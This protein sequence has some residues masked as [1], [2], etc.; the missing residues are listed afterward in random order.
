MEQDF[1]RRILEV[2]SVTTLVNFLTGFN[3]RLAIV[4]LPTIASSLHAD[5]WQSIWIIQ[6]YMLGSTIIQLVVGRLADLYGRVRL[7]NLGI[8]IFGLSALSAGAAPNPIILIVS[9]LLQ[10]VGGA[11]LMSLT[12]TLLTDYV[13][14]ERLATWLGINQVS[15]RVGALVGLTVSGFIIDALGWRWVFLVQFPVSLLILLWSQARLRDIYIPVERPVI[16]IVGFTLFTAFMSTLLVGLTLHGYG[17]ADISLATLVLSFATLT[18]FVFNELRTRSP[19][20]DLRLFRSWTFTGGIIA[21]LLYS[22]GFGASMTLLALYFQV[23]EG[24]S[25]SLTG[26]LMTPY[27]L[28]FMVF[29]VLGG[30]LSDIA[31][32]PIVSSV[33]LAIASFSLFGLY[34]ANTTAR[35]LIYESLLGVGTGLFV[36]PN[37]SSIMLSVPPERRGVASSLRTVS[38]NVGF[39]ASLNIAVLSITNFVPYKLAS[40]LITGSETASTL[41]TSSGTALLGKAVRYSFLIQSLIMASAIPFSI[42]RL[43]Q[44]APSSRTKAFGGL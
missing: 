28:A 4:G 38:F 7:F 17:F 13:P 29:G 31:G 40:M 8:A 10:G 32:Y 23:V 3:A 6:G 2:L 18:L 19:A 43:K 25:P 15:W 24:Y 20:L 34:T 35:I 21:Q 36:S 16:D 11:F 9:R 12:I 22:V 37:T 39:V 27:E 1:K 44:S 41:L 5:L 14:K 33:G 42:S 26:L 30:Y